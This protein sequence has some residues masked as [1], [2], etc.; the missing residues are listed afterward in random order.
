MAD[1]HMK[2]S[3]EDV[4][5]GDSGAPEGSLIT[6]VQRWNILKMMAMIFEL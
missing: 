1:F 4:D 6:F 2:T 5:I 3:D